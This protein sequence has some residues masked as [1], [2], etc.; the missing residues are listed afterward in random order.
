MAPTGSI[1]N[2]IPISYLNLTHTKLS[3]HEILDDIL[4]G[5]TNE[6][7]SIW[8]LSGLTYEL[9]TRL[10]DTPYQSISHKYDSFINPQ[11]SLIPC[12]CMVL[13]PDEWQISESNTVPLNGQQSLTWVQIKNV[14]NH[15]LRVLFMPATSSTPVKRRREW[16]C[17]FTQNVRRRMP[18]VICGEFAKPAV[19]AG[20]KWWTYL[21]ALFWS[22]DTH[23]IDD[24]LESGGL[25]NLFPSRSKRFLIVP[26]TWE[27]WVKEKNKHGPLS[28]TLIPHWS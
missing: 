13:V 2:D 26:V 4:E 12:Y 24:H 16:D 17:I 27:A 9:K 5:D 6:L 19:P 10:S 21:G 28:A 23:W 3:P 20:A 11:A 8:V 14:D 18:T 15:T 25:K 22:S 1:A 7:K